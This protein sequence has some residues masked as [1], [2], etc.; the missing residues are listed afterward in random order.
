MPKILFS[1]VSQLRRGI[2]FSALLIVGA[3]G[4][5]ACSA[6]SSTRVLAESATVARAT[7]PVSESIQTLEP[8]VAKPTS[9]PPSATITLQPTSTATPQSTRTA[10]PIPTAT[11]HPATEIAVNTAGNM[12]LPGNGL[13]WRL[14]SSHAMELAART[15]YSVQAWSPDG[16][17]LAGWSQEYDAP[18]IVTFETGEVT[19]LDNISPGASGAPA[20]SPDGRYLLYSV[21]IDDPNAEDE[22]RY[23]A[24]Y[25]LQTHQEQ[26]FSKPI[27]PGVFSGLGWSYDSRRIA[28]MSWLTPPDNSGENETVIKVVDV[29]TGDER[30]FSSPAPVWF[31]AGSWS[32]TDNKIVLFAN[33]KTPSGPGEGQTHYAYDEIYLLDVDTGN[34]EHLQ[35]P[36]SRPATADYGGLVD[37][38]LN[39][40]PWSPDGR[41][42]IYGDRGT[43]CYLTIS[44]REETCLPGVNEAIAQIG[45]VGGNYPSWSPDGE[46]I[47]FILKFESQYCSPVAAIK[48]DGSDF[49][50]TDLD[51]KIGGCTLFGPIWSPVMPLE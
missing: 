27:D 19:L 51:T 5:S 30:Q 4:M 44:S 12:L 25:D 26:L 10:T 28:Y 17:Q 22:I 31:L 42:I 37:Y 38:F 1:Q 2:I 49:Q 11:E 15:L 34:I 46:W 3:I 24:L 32:P 48:A 35:G 18:T 7:D 20:W 8:T 47:G 21:A 33:E 29:F 9:I 6:A 50:F 41:K 43:I 13:V 23:Y 40:I 45:A 39:R 36:G 16:T 14:G